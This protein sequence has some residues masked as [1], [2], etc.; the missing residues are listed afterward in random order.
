MMLA[1]K[2]SELSIFGASTSLGVYTPLNDPNT[3]E[4]QFMGVL[5]H[6]DS[7]GKVWQIKIT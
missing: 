3:L 2:F 4:S 6:H 7:K 5:T 1:I